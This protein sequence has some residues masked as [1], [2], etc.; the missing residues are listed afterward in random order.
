MIKIENV[1]ICG[2][3]PTIR[4]MRNPLNSWSKS[5]TFCGDMQCHECPDNQKCEFYHHDLDGGMPYRN[6]RTN[7]HDYIGPND[8]GLMERLAKGGPAHAKYRRFITVYLDIVA[9]LY[10]WKEFDTYKV[11][12][13][14]NSCS[15]MHKIADKEF[16][17]DDFS[18]EHLVDQQDTYVY[19]ETCEEFIG[20]KETLMVIVD[21]LNE[22]RRMY[23]ETKDKK[24]WWQMIQLLPS[25]YNQRR[26]IKLNYETLYRIYHDRKGHKLDE[27][28]EF[29]A[30]IES[31]PL[32]E[33]ITGPKIEGKQDSPWIPCTDENAKM[34]NEHEEV[35]CTLKEDWSL[36][37]EKDVQYHVFEGVYKT[38]KEDCY[39][40]PAANGKGYFESCNDWD[41]GQPLSVIAWMPKPEAYKE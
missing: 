6:T 27:W 15:T 29:C 13:D 38:Y 18:H 35:L 41:E 7:F 22:T 8:K 12:T 26:T 40:I 34:P 33:V 9:P 28:N 3:E 14:S 11:G 17:L 16:A 30:W 2:W 1:Q 4:G 23:L 31:L 20:P 5:D 36:G 37:D 10:W 24:Y 25:S 32:S 39:D 21:M 19:S